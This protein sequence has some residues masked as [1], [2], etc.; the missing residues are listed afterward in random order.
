MKTER[1]YSAGDN[2]SSTFLNL[3]KKI[4]WKQFA[5]RTSLLGARTFVFQQLEED[6]RGDE[7]SAFG[8]RE[9][10]VWSH[11]RCSLSL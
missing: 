4:Q 11:G 8:G 6:F 3:E 2:K 7:R 1:T 9:F 5:K 10:A